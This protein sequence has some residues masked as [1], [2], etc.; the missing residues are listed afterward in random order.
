[1]TE[2]QKHVRAS[3]V[4]DASRCAAVLCI[5]WSDSGPIATKQLQAIYPW[6]EKVPRVVAR[7]SIDTKVNKWGHAVTYCTRSEVFLFGALVS[8]DS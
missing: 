5:V 6:E 8:S 2:V 1:M 7:E 3:R 4:P